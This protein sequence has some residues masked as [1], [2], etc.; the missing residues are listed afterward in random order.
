MQGREAPDLD[1]VVAEVLHLGPDVVVL[2]E[3]QR[4][5]AAAVAERLGWHHR[6]WFKHWT[7]VYPAE[8]LAILSPRPIENPG[9]VHLAARWKFWSWKRRVA[10]WAMF[11]GVLVVNVHLGSGVGNPERAR[12]AGILLGAIGEGPAAVIAGDFNTAPNSIVMKA[13]AAAGFIESWSVVYPDATVATNWKSG[14]RQ[15]P[16]T[17]RLD[18]V[19]ARGP[20]NV[21]H[22][23][24][25]DSPM[26]AWARF[27]PLS[28]HVPITV[29]LKSRSGS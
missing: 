21:T 25:G 24:V 10:V 20:L 11:D 9:R 4:R 28:D 14:P 13:F 3:V 16:P 8:G 26:P 18:Y 1:S 2:Q 27:A 6:W 23:V 5:Q 17:Q 7:V 22:A 15:D 12:Q 19:L 29:T